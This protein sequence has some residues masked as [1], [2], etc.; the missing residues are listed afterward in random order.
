MKPEIQVA[1]PMRARARPLFRLAAALLMCCAPLAVT[2]QGLPIRMPD[3]AFGELPHPPPPDYAQGRYWAALPDRLEDLGEDG[4]DRLG[5]AAA[6]VAA[7]LALAALATTLTLTTLVLA[8]LVLTTLATASATTA[9]TTTT[10]TVAAGTATFTTA[11]ALTTLV[12]AALAGALVLA[13]TGGRRRRHLVADLGLAGR[14]GAV[15]DLGGGRSG[16][17]L[18]RGGRSLGVRGGWRVPALLLVVRHRSFLS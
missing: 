11:L 6:L 14:R 15:A 18:S 2:A 8:A 1:A 4:L 5:L 17:G 7:A 13:A 3:K 9:A 10:T 12:L 16:G